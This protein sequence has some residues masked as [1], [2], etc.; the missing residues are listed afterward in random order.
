MTIAEY[1]TR[2]AISDARREARAEGLKEGME[3]GFFQSAINLLN[4]GFSIEDVT[5]GTGLSREKV[6]ELRSSL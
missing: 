3:K 4:M 5:K 6:N 2:D 1:M